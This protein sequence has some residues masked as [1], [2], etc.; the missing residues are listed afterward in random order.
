MPQLC[1]VTPVSMA[2]RLGEQV[3]AQQKAWLNC[4]DCA[5]RRIMPGVTTG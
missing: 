1:G 5:A 2:E 3:G 4:S